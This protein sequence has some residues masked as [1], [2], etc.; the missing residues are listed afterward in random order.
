MAKN[1]FPGQRNHLCAL[2]ER[3]N[4]EIEKS[5]YNGALLDTLCVLEIYKKMKTLKKKEK[6]LTVV[7]RA[8]SSVNEN[9]RVI[10][11]LPLISTEE[12]PT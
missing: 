2:G 9:H 6:A 11:T 10:S 1:I 8:L 4:I 7:V 12:E 5:P 3:L